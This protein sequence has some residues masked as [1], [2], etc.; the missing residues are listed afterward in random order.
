MNSALVC[1]SSPTAYIYIYRQTK[2]KEKK[3]KQCINGV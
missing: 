3:E 2:K 1:D